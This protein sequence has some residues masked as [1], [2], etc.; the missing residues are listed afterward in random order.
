MLDA[1]RG[2]LEV[3]PPAARMAAARAQLHAA[4]GAARGAHA[5]RRSC[6]GARADGT[7]IEVFANVGSV[8]EALAAVRNGAEGCG[9]LRTEFLFLDRQAAPGEAEQR[10][11]YQGIADALGGRPLTIRTLDAGGDKPI[12]YLPLPPEENPALGLRGV[13]TSLAY[14]RA[15]ARAAARHT[16]RARPRTGPGAAA[17]DHGS[18]RNVDRCAPCS[19]T[20]ARGARPHRPVSVGVMIET[21]A[22]AVLAD[23]LRAQVADFLSIGT[24]D[25]TQ[26][27]LAMDRGHPQL[28]ARLDALHPAVLALIAAHRRGGARSRPSRGRVRRARLRAARGAAA[29]RPRRGR[30]LGRA[31]VIPQLKARIAARD[32]RASAAR[33]RTRRAASRARA[34]GARAAGP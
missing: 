23:A 11:A 22:S 15:A 10:D 27:T 9:L 4:R 28:A 19:S 20:L 29:G 1:E 12:A 16:R 3:D 2:V 17:D 34:R 21:P 32:A 30:A 14:P 25:L 26:Y 5:R 18:S 6:P 8:A 13:R 7:R 31:G 33:S 24:N